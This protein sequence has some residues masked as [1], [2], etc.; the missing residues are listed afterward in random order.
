MAA[1][2]PKMEVKDMLLAIHEMGEVAGAEAVVYV[3]YRYAGSAGVQHR[4]QRRKSL[5]A[6]AIPYARR[7]RNHRPADQTANDRCERTLHPGYHDEHVGIEERLTL[8]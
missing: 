7:N 6:G 8:I 3:H 1:S 5:E 4:Q 2:W